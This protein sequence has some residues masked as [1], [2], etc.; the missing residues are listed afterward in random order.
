MGEQGVRSNTDPASLRALTLS[1]LDDLDAVE[2]MLQHG[3]VESGV[4]RIGAE[5]EM[6][7]I[8]SSWRPA[9]IAMELLE[10]LDDE[11]FV[12]EL[13]LYNLEVNLKPLPWGA[14][15]L[16]GMLQ[17]L[18]ACCDRVREIAGRFDARPLLTGTLPTLRKTDIGLENMTP[19]PRYRA[20]NE[21]MNA[22]RG[23]P[24]RLYV[25]GVDELSSRHDSVMLESCCTSFQVHLQVGPEEFAQRYNTA[26]AVLPMVLAASVNSP[27]LFGRRLWHE[28]RIPL[29]QQ[30]IDA[31]RTGTHLREA[32]PRVRFGE[33]WLD[34]SILEL[35]REDA[36]RFRLLLDGDDPGDPFA[37]IAVGEAPELRALRLHAGTVYRWN[38]GCYGVFEGRPHLRIEM[39]ALPSG[40]TPLD[41]MANAAFFYGLVLGLP[42]S[43][44]DVRRVLR[45][46]DAR[47]NFQAA[48]KHGLGAQVTWFG[49]NEMGIRELILETLLPIALA[50]LLD[51]GID[52]TEARDFLG[53]IH[54]RVASQRTGARWQLGSYAR[55][56]AAG[57]TR[58]QAVTAITSD[59]ARLQDTGQPVHTWPWAELEG[60]RSMN[61]ARLRVEDV[62]STDLHTIG[63]DEPVDLVGKIMQWRGIRHIPVEDTD[64]R[65]LGML[66]CFDVL[67]YLGERR[68]RTESLPASALMSSTTPGIGPEAPVGIALALMREQSADSLPVIQG[69]RL[70]GIVT[71]RDLIRILWQVL[72]ADDPAGR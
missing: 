54:D 42:S 23:G 40:P 60:G 50:G 17:Q 66:S 11:R 30:S 43:T 5:Q 13:G 36:V 61:P 29:F 58:E 69:E 20:L 44:P 14:R 72:Q 39:R 37:R 18:T 68:P 7:L 15:C 2:Y 38:R 70:V 19:K 49:G 56:A 22:L 1:L 45:F 34:D 65:L 3:L 67:R 52:A 27:I 35:L 31:R 26:Q 28:T 59:M 24:W 57:A 63:P 48:A 51:H 33:R 21:A 53:V 12:T 8:D 47:A 41:E 46:D 71:E 62:M 9:P 16:S 32:A 55:L 64:H 4:R 10:A 25:R 6:F